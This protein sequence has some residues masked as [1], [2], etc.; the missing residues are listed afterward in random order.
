MIPRDEQTKWRSRTS[1]RQRGVALLAVL[2]LSVALTMIAMT[3]A[4]LVR[5]EASAVGNHMEAERAALLAQ[6]AVQAAVYAILHPTGNP[7]PVAGEASLTQQF[8]PGQ[9][10]IHFD[11]GQGS[12]EVEV[13]PENAKINI[14]LA[15]PEQL[16]ALFALLGMPVNQSQELAAAI[17]D[18]RSPRASS[19]ST[20]FD[21]FYANLPQ[22]YEARHAPLEQLEELLA[23]KGMSRDLFFGQ[24]VETS[25]EAWKRTPPLP[26]LLTTEPFFG[27]VNVH[28]APYEVLRVLPGWDESL[29]RAVVEARSRIAPGT[30]MVSVP[31]LSGAMSVSP[32]TFS[33]GLTYT[34]TATAQMR[35]SGVRHSVR[36]RIRFDRS[37][38]MGYQVTA[39]W[40]DWPWSPVPDLERE[41]NGGASA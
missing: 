41:R 12:A 39:W 13:I 1:R 21:L 5:T 2:W 30:L 15:T 20:P 40:Q 27:G 25:E 35:D 18:W 11:F 8:R 4:Y 3:T 32:V 26:D 10:W 29:A 36:A 31:G 34:L 23:V 28:Y 33:T 16:E 7:T 22:P 14:N 6:G 38:P 9:R 24:F 17:A 37:L 19:I